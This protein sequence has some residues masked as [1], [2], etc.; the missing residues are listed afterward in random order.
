MF[1]KIRIYALKVQN[2][3]EEDFKS[4]YKNTRIAVQI[5][6]LAWFAFMIVSAVVFHLLSLSSSFIET[7]TKA[8]LAISLIPAFVYVHKWSIHDDEYR[9]RTMDLPLDF[10]VDKEKYVKVQNKTKA[11]GVCLLLCIL[12]IAVTDQYFY[13]L[14]SHVYLYIAFMAITSFLLFHIYDLRKHIRKNFN[15][16]HKK[17]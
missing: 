9:R 4:S 17:N 7:F 13:S 5:Y 10:E 14:G 8:F 2:L 15:E 12:A 16:N 1:Q 6:F 3:S 11:I